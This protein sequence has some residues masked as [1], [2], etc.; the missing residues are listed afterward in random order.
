[1][2]VGKTT[3]GQTKNFEYEGNNSLN[4]LFDVDSLDE[5]NF[6]TNSCHPKAFKTNVR[7]KNNLIVALHPY[8]K[9]GLMVLQ[10]STPPKSATKG[11]PKNKKH[12]KKQHPE[13]DKPE[14]LEFVEVEEEDSQLE[15]IPPGG[16]DFIGN[17]H[18]RAKSDK[19]KHCKDQACP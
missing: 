12:K 5:G 7:T 16:A 14:V 1:M 8:I 18:F 9:G 15:V 6:I 2:Q 3:Y 4:L 17:P 10:A 11:K 19:R 13:E